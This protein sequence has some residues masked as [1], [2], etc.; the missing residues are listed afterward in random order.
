MAMFILIEAVVLIVTQYAAHYGHMMTMESHMFRSKSVLD[1]E[2]DS[3][4]FLQS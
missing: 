2:E 3:I 4:C 1:M